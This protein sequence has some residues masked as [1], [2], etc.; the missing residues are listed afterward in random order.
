MSWLTDKEQ[1]ELLA[2]YRDTTTTKLKE[3]VAMIREQD[4]F[5][6][7]QARIDAAAAKSEE[8]AEKLRQEVHAVHERANAIDANMRKRGALDR[9]VARLVT[10]RIGENDLD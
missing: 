5:T 9:D 1:Q 2:W 4:V 10:K 3:Y 8:H 7:I 6:K